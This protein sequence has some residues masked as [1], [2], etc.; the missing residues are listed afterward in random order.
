MY[1]ISFIF[2]ISA[3]LILNFQRTCGIFTTNIGKYFFVC[4]C[5]WKLSYPLLTCLGIIWLKYISVFL[6]YSG[7]FQMVRHKWQRDFLDVIAKKC[8][9]STGSEILRKQNITECNLSV[10]LNVSFLKLLNGLWLRF[11]L[12]LWIVSGEF[13]FGPCQLMKLKSDLVTVLLN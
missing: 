7:C 10:I 4:V 6:Y 8:P 5:E 9:T 1:L 12:V 3:A 11:I 2:Q 13:H